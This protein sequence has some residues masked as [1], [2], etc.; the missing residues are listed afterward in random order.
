MFVC[1]VSYSM[2]VYCHAMN[3]FISVLIKKMSRMH[4]KHAHS[5]VNFSDKC[6][7]GAPIVPLA[8]FDVIHEIKGSC[9]F[10]F[11]RLIISHF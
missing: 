9:P 4:V 11:P 2:F 7:S 10:L 5:H 3:A 6:F 1:N 8:E